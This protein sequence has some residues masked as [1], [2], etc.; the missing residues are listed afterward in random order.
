[1]PGLG[2]TPLESAKLAANRDVGT[3]VLE[4]YSRVLES[5]VATMKQMAE[6]VL[7]VGG[8]LEDAAAAAAAAAA[9]TTAATAASAA[10]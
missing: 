3:A 2:Q 8:Q 5:R 9:A 6:E 4:A 10:K 1:M 7:A